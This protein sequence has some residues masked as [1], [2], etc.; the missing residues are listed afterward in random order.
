VRESASYPNLL[1]GGRSRRAYRVT[2]GAR[3]LSPPFFFGFVKYR[4]LAR[5]RIA[6]SI[7][8]P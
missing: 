4:R 2:V 1:G 8:Q 3:G 7:T 5:Q 6:K